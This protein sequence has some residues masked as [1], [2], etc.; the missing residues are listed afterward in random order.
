MLTLEIILFS[1]GQRKETIKNCLV[2]AKQ[3]V[4]SK[5]TDTYQTREWDI[6]MLSHSFPT[7]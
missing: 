4:M 5:E 2:L 6:S 1:L 7:T 3:G